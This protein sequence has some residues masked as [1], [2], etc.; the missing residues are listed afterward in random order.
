MP[1]PV[2]NVVARGVEA[3]RRGKAANG[4][5]QSVIPDRNREGPVLGA[6]EVAGGVGDKLFMADF[7]LPMLATGLAWT[8]GKLPV[9]GP[10]IQLFTDGI[11]RA[12]IAAAKATTVGELTANIKTLPAAYFQEMATLSGRSPEAGLRFAGMAERMGGVKTVKAAHVAATS[13]AFGTGALQRFAASR[14]ASGLKSLTQE[15]DGVVDGFNKPQGG[16]I[17]KASDFFS[18]TKTAPEAANSNHPFTGVEAKIKD[19]KGA[20]EGEAH[21]INMADAKAHLEGAKEALKTVESTT[22]NSKQAAIVSEQITSFEQRLEQIGS[23]MDTA[24]GGQNLSQAAKSGLKNM[25]VFDVA[26]KGGMAAGAT[27]YTG[28]TIVNFKQA[29]SGLQELYQDLTGKP[30]SFMSVVTG[31]NLPPMMQEAR[32]NMLKRFVPEALSAAASAGLNLLWMKR[33]MGMREHLMM[34]GAMLTQ[35]S[36]SELMPHENFLE[37]YLSMKDLQKAGHP[38]PAEAYSLLVEA[39]SHDARDVGGVESRLIQAIGADYAKEQKPVTEVLK[40]IQDKQPYLDRAQRVALSI[41][42][43]DDAKRTASLAKAAT[44]TAPEASSLMQAGTGG[45]LMAAQHEGKLVSQ[46]QERVQ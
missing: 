24:R 7:M 23:H 30:I 42:D 8:V 36:I 34:G 16:I 9:I 43:I 40:E 20:L 21:Q 14:A 26:F 27:Y 28:R 17:K 39:A 38:V 18:K 2:T 45:A 19:F 25:S 22:Q 44:E 10:R 12:P 37:T 3:N 29:V 46:Q 33:H 32:S 31:S 6:L 11:L 5:A 35:M 1:A 41:K 13:G 15:A 4:A